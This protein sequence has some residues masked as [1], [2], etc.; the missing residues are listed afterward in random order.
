[1]QFTRQAPIHLLRRED[2]Q[3]LHHGSVQ[4]RSLGVVLSLS[5][6]QHR[7]DAH[8]CRRESIVTVYAHPFPEA[9]L[10]SVKRYTRPMVSVWIALLS[11]KEP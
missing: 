5:Q 7:C 11:P 3:C 6:S 4:E 9:L 8:S 10:I 1:M 2:W